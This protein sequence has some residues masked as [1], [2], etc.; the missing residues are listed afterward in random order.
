MGYQAWGY[1][2]S[3][4]QRSTE[5]QPSPPG[6][7]PVLSS[8][9]GVNA[10]GDDSASLHPRSIGDGLDVGDGPLHQHARTRP[11]SAAQAAGEP[12]LACS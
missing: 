3:A 9:V 4:R 2:A 7:Q 10:G 5:P 1:Q 8:L 12:S 6:V 11:S